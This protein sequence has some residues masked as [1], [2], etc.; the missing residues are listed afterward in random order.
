MIHNHPS[1]VIFALKNIPTI[2]L[3]PEPQTGHVNAVFVDVVSGPDAGNFL[4]ILPGQSRLIGRSR[5]CDLVVDDPQISAE[6]LVISVSQIVLVRDLSTTNGTVL[7]RLGGAAIFRDSPL[8]WES[9]DL[10]QIGSHLLQ[11]RADSPQKALTTPYSDSASTKKYIVRASPPV[12]GT[13]APPPLGPPPRAP[14]GPVT[15]SIPW[16]S[17]LTSAGGGLIM[18]SIFRMAFM[19]VFAVLAPAG[20]LLQF[21]WERRRELK[22]HLAKLND[23]HAEL[24]AHEREVEAR[25]RERLRIA[26]LQAFDPARA[27]RSATL[28]STE[29]WGFSR[30]DPSEFPL[31]LGFILDVDAPL[32]FSVPAGSAPIG[33]T[34]SGAEVTPL[35]RWLALQLATSFGP[36]AA[37]I[38]GPGD[39]MKRLPHSYRRKTHFAFHAAAQNDA[40]ST[41]E[42][43]HFIFSSQR[44]QLPANCGVIINV[45]ADFSALVEDLRS[46]AR[47]EVSHLI[48]LTEKTAEKW[49]ESLGKLRDEESVPRPAPSFSALWNAPTTRTIAERWNSDLSPGSELPIPLGDSLAGGVVTLDVAREGPH[50]LIGGTT[51]S[52]KSVLQRVLV[53]SLALAQRPEHLALVLI[54]YKGGAAFRCL[55]KLPHVID[56]V[57]DLDH[58]ATVRTLRALRAELRRREQLLADHGV[59]DHE[60]LTRAGHIAAAPRLIIVVDELRALADQHPELL[61]ELIAL[62]GQ[63][64][65]LGMHL[66]LATQRPGSV[67][68]G[69]MSANINVRIA[70]RVQGENESREILGGPAAAHLDQE[71][72]GAALLR[73]G[74]REP[75]PVQISDLSDSESQKISALI[76]QT[77]RSVGAQSARRPWPEP[78]PSVLQNSDLESRILN[79]LPE[80]IPAGLRDHAEELRQDPLL[81]EFAAGHLLIVGGP[82]SGRTSALRTLAHNSRVPTHIIAA[83]ASQIARIGAP[84]TGSV[85]DISDS[86][87]LGRLLQHLVQQT[88]HPR[89]ILIDDIDL[90]LDPENSHAASWRRIHALFRVC[91]END[92]AIAVAGGRLSLTSRLSQFISQRWVLNWSDETAHSLLGIAKSAPI[93]PGPGGALEIHSAISVPSRIAWLSPAHSRAANP[94][95]TPPSEAVQIPPPRLLALPSRLGIRKLNRRTLRNMPTAGYTSTSQIVIGIG[96]DFAE[97]IAIPAV[98]L[99]IA[100]PPGSGKTNT[101]HVL[102][103]QF[104]AAGHSPRFFNSN[105]S[106]PEI[107]AALQGDI[108]LVDDIDLAH[109]WD[110]HAPWVELLRNQL[111]AQRPIIASASTA[112]WISSYT[113]AL[114]QFR[115]LRT[116]IVLQAASRGSDDIFG[117]SLSDHANHDD[118]PG[119]AALMLDQQITALQLALNDR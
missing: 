92:I 110:P 94:P 37:R 41:P 96:G 82:G 25:E 72:P 48:G 33:I 59:S 57:T 47:H 97:P 23:F 20:M 117:I 112:A 67:V 14:A 44:A 11:L 68:T 109:N 64:R 106:A 102:E 13:S 101:L 58:A 5:L 49:A 8:H 111:R 116:G 15:R 71:R 80:A 51:G 24:A 4:R 74:G 100:G 39:W 46:D 40:R 119:R 104:R 45:R 50:V 52:G 16:L 26:R 12:L 10:L 27:F 113:G 56:T 6:H 99:L 108:V 77:A 107:T 88:R 62:A 3:A 29:L 83:P 30:C 21:W 22:K 53:S 60:Q 70:L 90:I 54:D 79:P 65:S 36:G 55:E 35:V 87:L 114:A 73:V 95:N 32:P 84:H 78:L 42:A 63:G 38:S 118:P 103:R 98:P 89:L 18:A 66:I 31:L 19:L 17:L 76:A 105:A 43:Q 85:I 34:G 86:R 61:S 81:F 28:P 69:E 91:Q 93:P 1:G 2:L 9:A 115:R 7:H 75:V